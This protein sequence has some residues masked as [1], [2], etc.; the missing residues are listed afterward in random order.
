MRA[1]SLVFNDVGK[2]KRNCDEKCQNS[3]KK[4]SIG[5]VVFVLKNTDIDFIHNVFV[6]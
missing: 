3:L 6:K 5:S 4:L 1:V 2:E